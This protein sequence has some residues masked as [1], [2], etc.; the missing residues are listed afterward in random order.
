MSKIEATTLKNGLRVI[1]DTVPGMH[2]AAVGIWAGVGTRDEAFPDNG[3]AHMV[4]HMLF[5]G[6]KTRDAQK[7][8]EDIE[9]VGG[10]VNAYTSRELTS[11]HIHLLGEDV[12]LALDILA[13]MYTGSTLP[14]DEL[15]RERH[16]VL[17]EIG[18][19]N[20]TPDDLIFDH[21]YETAYPGQS[22]GAPI[23][24]RSDYIGGIGRETLRAYMER[25]YTPARTVISAAGAVDHD[26]F[27]AQV[28]KLFETLPA[29]TDAAKPGAD[30]Q[31]GECR[32]DKDL[33]QSHFILGFEGV[34]RLDED[35]YA[36]QALSNI[37]G[38]GMSSRLFQEVREKRGLAY[39][40]FSFHSGYQD[41]GQFGIYAGTGPG[42]LERAMDVVCAE[43]RKFASTL[44]GGEL[45][46]ARAQLKAGVLMGRESM[47]SRAD[48]QARTLLFKNEAFDPEAL[49]ARIDAIDEEAVRRVAERIFRTKPT[50]A[51]LGPLETL[52]PYDGIAG[53]L[54]A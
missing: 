7:I 6:T 41:N 31:G 46:R 4:E 30:Y 43:V 48:Q 17:Q 8:A 11:Y 2:S 45:S 39:S 14:E 12:P 20:D 50:L 10:S 38:G 54:A 13:D 32:L 29:D 34:S 52:A 42:D 51:A 40:V 16:V 1:T 28:E 24:G 33:E 3:V 27:A 25:F 5:K 44:E 35:Y 19:C 22:L 26:A 47:M 21:Y 36:A 9:N 15:E 23:L 37:L 18:M 49:I 53:R